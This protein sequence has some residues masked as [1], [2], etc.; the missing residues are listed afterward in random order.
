[1]V[2]AVALCQPPENCLVLMESA[3]TH[4]QLSK[5]RMDQQGWLP[6]PGVLEKISKKT[7]NKGKNIN[8]TN[9]TAI[10]LEGD[11][12]F[13]LRMVFLKPQCKEHEYPSKE[14]EYP[15]KAWLAL[16]FSLSSPLDIYTQEE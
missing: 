16:P 9:Q 10:L 15:N 2:Q 11:T 1:M 14:H 8:I 12:P 13:E 7:W 5:L 6:S 4:P 3:I